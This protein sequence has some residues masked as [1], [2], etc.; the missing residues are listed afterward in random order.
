MQLGSFAFLHV[1]SIAVLFSDP[2]SV[3]LA[4]SGRWLAV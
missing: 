3:A 4:V 1:F 2:P